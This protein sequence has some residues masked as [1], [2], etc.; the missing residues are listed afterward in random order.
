MITEAG[1]DG[2]IAGEDLE[3]ERSILKKID[4][5]IDKHGSSLIFVVGHHDCGGNPVDDDVHLEQIKV[6]VDKVKSWK[7]AVKVIGLWVNDKWEV[8]KVIEK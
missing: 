1:M 6:S 8:E 7:P 4:I 2:V 3:C 5:S